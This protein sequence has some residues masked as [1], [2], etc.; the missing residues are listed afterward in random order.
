MGRTDLIFSLFVFLQHYIG[1]AMIGGDKQHIATRLGRRLD[2]PQLHIQRLHGLDHRIKIPRMPHHVSVGEIAPEEAIF[3]GLHGG[4]EMIRNLPAFHGRLLVKGAVV[5]GDL[6]IGLQLLG[7]LSAAVSIPEICDMAVLLGLR[8]GILVD[9]MGHQQLCKGM[10]NAGRLHQEPGRNMRISVILQHPGKL[11]IM[12]V[13]PIK[14]VKILLVKGPADFQGPIP[15]EIEQ[16]HTVSRPDG[17]HRFPVPGYDE[18]VEVLIDTA[19]LP[20]LGFNGGFCIR[21]LPPYPM[22]MA[23]KSPFHHIPVRLIAVHGQ[24]HP[25]ASG[26]NDAGEGLIVERLQLPLQLRHIDQG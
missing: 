19:G 8:Q 20:P 17:S 25:S 6:L 16:N 14:L 23:I 12:E 9:A 7:D 22:D 3:P 2:S 18:F 4:N 13:P 15:A 11:H 5:R 24:V 26:G 10:R 21:E 1:I